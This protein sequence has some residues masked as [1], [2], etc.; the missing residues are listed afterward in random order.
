MKPVVALDFDG[1]ICDS[2]NECMLVAFGAYQAWR[3]HGESGPLDADLIPASFRDYFRAFRYLVRPAREY[4]IIVHSFYEG[5]STL[6]WSRFD[7]LSRKCAAEMAQ[8]EPLYF[9][10]RNTFRSNDCEKWLQLH[11]LYNEF[12]E[13]WPCLKEACAPYIVTTRDQDSLGRLLHA[14]GIE[15]PDERCWTKER[16]ETKPAAISRIAQIQQISVSEVLFIDDHLEY[17]REVSQ[18]GASV[19]WAG[20]GFWKGTLSMRESPFERL[21]NLGELMKKEAFVR[22]QGRKGNEL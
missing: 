3:T 18:I 13:P 21:T 16:L 6:S 9:A 12:S 2:M 10:T 20:W 15:I 4:W 22:R 5:C 1:V 19:F 11:R 7:R 17:L 14:F 8:F